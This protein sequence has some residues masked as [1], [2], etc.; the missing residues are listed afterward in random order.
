M[1]KALGMVQS[2]P[3]ERKQRAQIVLEH[4]GSLT[5]TSRSPETT[6]LIDFVKFQF[7]ACKFNCSVNVCWLKAPMISRQLP[8]TSLMVLWTPVKLETPGGLIEPR[9]EFPTQTQGFPMWYVF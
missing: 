9:L 3:P 7:P 2:P 5:A 1:G 6:N 4:L 8:Q